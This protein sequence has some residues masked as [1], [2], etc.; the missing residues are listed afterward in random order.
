MFTL[1]FATRTRISRPSSE[2]HTSHLPCNWG[3]E[4]L[5]DTGSRSMLVGTI[6]GLEKEKKP[7]E[8]DTYVF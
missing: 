7:P 5:V 6:R 1:K 3:R 8:Q 2:S 4:T